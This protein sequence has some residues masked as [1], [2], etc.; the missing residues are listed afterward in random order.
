MR[1]ATVWGANGRTRLYAAGPHAMFFDVLAAAGPAS[2]IPEHVDDVGS[3]YR[4][5]AAA[6]GEVRRLAGSADT[7]PSSARLSE[8]ELAPPVT[9]PGSIV[10]IGRNY[11]AHAQEGNSP[12]PEFPVLFSKFPNTLVGH[13]APVIKHAITNELDY[14]GELA[15]VMGRRASRVAERDAMDFVAGYTIVNDISARDLQ[16]GDL[17]WI[18]GKSLDTFCP[19]GP[20]YVSAEEVADPG[21]L[22]IETR[23]N[24]ELRQ[25]APVSDML[26]G[27]P[28]LIAFITQGITLEPG[29]I[30]ATGTP[31][32]VAFGMKP[33]VYLEPGD[34]IEVSISGLGTL[35]SPIRGPA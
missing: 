27:I 22:E 6:V 5:G 2:V 16:L 33:P 31:S 30:I 1:L 29:D 17:Q 9:S 32:G 13:E 15:V 3:L 24:G 11:V 10:C 25:H 34:V 23:V 19:M 4:A 7:A 21:A 20:V 12:I 18:R 26:F 8:L 14:E 35:R 28:R